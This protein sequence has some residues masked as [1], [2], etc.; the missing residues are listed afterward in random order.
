MCMCD[1]CKDARRL[2]FLIKKHG[3]LKKAEQREMLSITERLYYGGAPERGLPN[4]S[5]EKPRA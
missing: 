4:S 5:V 2:L 1:N 3:K